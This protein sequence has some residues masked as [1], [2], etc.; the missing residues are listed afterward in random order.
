MHKENLLHET[1]KVELKKST[2][3][4]K[5]AIISISAILN[6]HNKGAL[7]F[8]VKNDGTVIGQDVS[9][10]TLREISQAI[11]SHIEAKIYPEIT[12][13]IIDGKECVKVQFLG[14]EIPYF[15]YGKPYIRVA[16]EDKLMSV[17]ELKKLI[18]KTANYLWESRLSDKKFNDINKEALQQFIQR[19]NEAKRI[20]FKFTTVKD[21][22]AK[23]YL[24]KSDKLLRAAEVL[25]CNDNTVE[26]QA[27]VFAGT[28]KLTFLDI[29]QFKGNLLSLKEQSENYI[30][31][32]INWRANLT[33]AGRE[34][35]PEIPLRA[36]EEAIVNS[37]CHRDYSIQKSNEIAFY[38]DRI[39]MFNPG[40]FPENKEPEDYFKGKGESILRNPLIANTLYLSKDI[41]KWGSGIKRIYDECKGAGIKVVFEKESTGFKVIFY[42]PVG[43]V[44]GGLNE[45]L[46]EGLKSL[47][48]VIDENP[49]IKAKDTSLLLNNRPL[50]TIER[51]IT[52]LV[53]K[54]L[55]ERKGSKKTGGYFIKQ[56]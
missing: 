50:K 8:G 22:L 40:Q 9:E 24:I 34:E 1:E 51:Q 49:G 11:A 3:E 7:Y 4:L 30:K 21:V 35:I 10:S 53:E 5:E 13:E 19:A 47:L 23:L 36:I 41:E 46:N 56:K 16:D 37:L 31:E 33:S 43:F 28:D 26:V 14:D 54:S 17:N 45:G 6:K 27:A 32:H 55:I 38:S 48:K 42:R 52:I 25:F 20:N 12:K 2:A 44:A 39:E 15:A 18:L 29:K